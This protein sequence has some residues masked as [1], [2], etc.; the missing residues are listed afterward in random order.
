MNKQLKADLSLLL[1]TVVWGTTFVITKNAL[2]HMETFNFLA[3]RFI[4]A[5][6]TSS[7]LFYKNMK[8]INK[9]TLIYG[10]IIGIILFLGYALQTIGLN[11]TTASKS[12]FITGFSVIIVPIISAIILKRTPQKSTIIGVILAIV[13]LGFM[14]LNSSLIPNI[15]DFFTLIAAFFFAFHILSVERY[16]G[17]VDS[18]S[19]AI[20][21]IGV[22]GI[23]SLIISLSFES[24]TIPTRTDTWIGILITSILATSGAY[25]IQNTMQKFTSATHTALIYTAEPVFSA[26]FAFILLHEIMSPQAIFG[27]VLILSGMILGEVKFKKKREMKKDF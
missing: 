11:Y 16:T 5:F 26:I 4:L 6:I 27:S 21:Q 1:V 2:S 20:I 7:L 13:G 19:L 9:V 12:G 25:I 10:V 15:G 3:I 14:T 23:I 8:N 24:F 18:I 22:V 17:D